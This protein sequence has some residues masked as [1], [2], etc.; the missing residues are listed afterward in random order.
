VRE[1][2]G[3]SVVREWA[4]R[5]SLGTT[6]APLRLVLRATGSGTRLDV[7]VS[8]GAARAGDAFLADLVSLS[9][10]V[11]PAP[12][13]VA[14]KATR[15]RKPRRVVRPARRP[16]PAR[17]PKRAPISP[18]GGL[19]PFRGDWETGDASQWY[20]LKCADVSRQFRI[21]TS[22]VR[23]GRYAARFEVAPGDK[24]S[25][26]GERCEAYRHYDGDEA[27]GQDS[28]YAWSTLFPTDWSEPSKYGM[29]LQFHSV[30]PVP[31][32]LEVSMRGDSAYVIA[33]GHDAYDYESHRWDILP[34]LG[35]GKWNDFIMYVSW[36]VDGGAVK[37]W[38]R[39]EG[40]SAF[41]VVLD[42]TNVPTVMTVNGVPGKNYVRYGLYRGSGGTNTNVLYQD[43]FRRGATYADVAA[44]FPPK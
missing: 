24:P 2:R 23:Q 3:S 19:T 39:V 43:G 34:T 18:I 6:F 32:P 17:S 44:D 8:E 14:G 41:R 11:V 36:R 7:R 30:W 15:H 12:G 21:V 31:P 42:K 25:S 29:M 10:G 28:Y 27:S 22:P 20:G 38:H 5:S 40:E 33:R 16:G 37:I 1:Y 13:A 4:T 9:R 26:T 35:K